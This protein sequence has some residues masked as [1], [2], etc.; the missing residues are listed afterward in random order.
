MS[1]QES[2]ESNSMK[3]SGFI[4]SQVSHGETT[5]DLATTQNNNN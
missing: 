1:G 3:C 4:D 5:P 2:T